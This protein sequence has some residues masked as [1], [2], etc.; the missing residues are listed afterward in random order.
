MM[1]ISWLYV[2]M[3]CTLELIVFVSFIIGLVIA[4]Y[5]IS[6]CYAAKLNTIYFSKQI[7]A[8]S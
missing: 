7:N 5:T 3:A 4:Y 2:C 6:V 8:L 1:F